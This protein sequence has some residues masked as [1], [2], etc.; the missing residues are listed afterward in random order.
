M[1]ISRILIRDKMSNL[2]ETF[3]ALQA[4]PGIRPWDATILD[5]WGASGDPGHGSVCAVRFVLSVW[6]PK[7]TYESGRFDLHEALG[8]W[9]EENTQAFRNW[10]NDPWWP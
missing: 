8:V 9:D 5:E 1:T 10:I 6:N 7:L 4:A 2:A 3:P